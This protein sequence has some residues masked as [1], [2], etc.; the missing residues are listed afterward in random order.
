MRYYPCSEL[1]LTDVKKKL[2]NM[3]IKEEN[4]T[5]LLS[6][7]GIYKYVNDN[8]MI[9]KLN[10]NEE[11]HLLKNYIN[12]IDFI[13]SP[14]TWKRIE[15]RHNIPLANRKINVKTYYFSPNSKS[16]FKFV[17]EVYSTGKIDY[18]F[19]SPEEADDYSLKEDICSFLNALT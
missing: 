11:E 18:Y 2:S 6:L 14:N 8:L 5:W 12:N 13:I 4:E 1:L 16:R 10:L 9:Y 3:V 15:V 17:M 19:S 7:H